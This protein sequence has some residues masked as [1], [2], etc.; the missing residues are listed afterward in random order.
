MLLGSSLKFL[1]MIV[2]YKRG[3]T[4]S[5]T[6]A[7]DMRNDIITSVVAISCATIGYYYWAYADPVGAIVVCGSIAFSWFNNALGYVPILV[8][9]RGE[10]D[11]LSRILKIV[12]EHDERIRC[13]DHVMVYHTG[14]QA[15]VEIHIVL[16]ENLPLKIT[17]DICHP[18]EKKLL[19]LDFI[20]R[21]F[22]HC[23]YDCDGD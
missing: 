18:L 19:K 20:E 9:V 7:M 15:T 3:T 23:D 14:P 21:A 5:K 8:G 6:L 22:V 4:S 17:H 10:R 12:I 11:E 1:L 16:D 13:I 2:C